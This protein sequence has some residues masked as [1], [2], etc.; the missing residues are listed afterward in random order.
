MF[1]IHK[2]MFTVDEKLQE[3]VEKQTKTSEELQNLGQIVF[4]LSSTLEYY[5]EYK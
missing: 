4:F 1:V 5:C 3:M 2:R